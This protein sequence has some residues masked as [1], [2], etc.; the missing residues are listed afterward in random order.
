M[1]YCGSFRRPVYLVGALPQP[2][3]LTRQPTGMRGDFFRLLQSFPWKNVPLLR[4]L[5]D[6]ELGFRENCVCI[7]SRLTQFM[8]FFHNREKKEMFLPVFN[9][10]L[11]I[12]KFTRFV[13]RL[14]C[15]FAHILYNFALKTDQ[16]WL[17]C[18]LMNFTALEKATV[19]QKHDLVRMWYPNLDLNR[20]F[21]CWSKIFPK[22]VILIVACW[23]HLPGSSLQLMPGATGGY[24]RMYITWSWSWGSKYR[25]SQAQC[26]DKNV[27]AYGFSVLLNC[28]LWV[29]KNGT[30]LPTALSK[31]P[32]R[33]DW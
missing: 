33:P 2:R 9:T 24:H 29:A 21:V 31:S 32:L 7:V 22:A 30:F 8:G 16:P 27:L 13:A 11:V 4:L 26:K 1:I 23:R 3:H 19:P 5:T 14:S 20:P 17:I 15:C 25:I 12:C 10:S 28:W 18:L 6:C